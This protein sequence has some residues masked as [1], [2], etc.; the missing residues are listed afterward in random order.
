MLNHYR[1]CQTSGLF[2]SKP[3]LSIG[4]KKEVLSFHHIMILYV[5]NTLYIHTEFLSLVVQLE[6]NKYCENLNTVCKETVSSGQK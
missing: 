1:V 3:T 2:H 5:H 4:Q 6:K